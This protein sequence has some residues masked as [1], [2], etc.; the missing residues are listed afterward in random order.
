MTRPAVKHRNIS[1]LR[2]PKNRLSDDEWEALLSHFLLQIQPE[3][4]QAKVL[5]GV[6]VMYSLEGEQLEVSFRKDVDGIKVRRPAG[7]ALSRD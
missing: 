2:K 3:A 6:R 4:A 1:K 7:T 5:E